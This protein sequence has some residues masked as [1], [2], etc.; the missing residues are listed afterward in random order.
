MGF[1]FLRERETGPIFAVAGGS[2]LA[3]IRAILT[4]AINNSKT[5]QR[6]VNLWFGARTESDVYLEEELKELQA[7][8]PNFKVDIVL[9]ESKDDSLRRTGLVTEAIRSDLEKLGK[10]ALDGA[11]A[12]LAGPP[13]MVEAAQ[14]IFIAAGLD[15]SRIH[16]DAFY[17]EEDKAALD[18]TR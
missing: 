16:A 13:K 3:P 1:A 18:I 15:N 7:A 2:G 17:T 8:C 9:S 14:E 4:A 6:P 11:R 5:T 10:Q 12:Y